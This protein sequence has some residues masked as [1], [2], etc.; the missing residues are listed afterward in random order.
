MQSV[1]ELRVVDLKTL[2]PADLEECWAC[3][4]RWWREQLSWDISDTVEA[5]RRVV[6][7]HGVPGQAV[8]IGARTVGYTYYGLVGRLGVISGVHVLP[9][10]SHAAVGAPLLQETV[11]A[12]RQQGATRIESP[13]LAM[14][15]PWLVPVL[16]QQGFQTHW[17]EFLRLD[18][19]RQEAPTPWRG[20][21]QLEPWQR[22]HRREAV[23]I[24]PQVYA[25]SSDADGN[26][27]YRTREGC[28]L[29]LE[30][31]L[32][33]GS[34]GRLI[35]TASACVRH[36]G[37]GIGCILVTEIAPAQ[38][39]L[40]QV[41]V[42]PDYQRQGVGRMLLRYSMSQLAARHYETLSLLVSRANARALHMYQTLGWHRV[43]AFPLAVWEQTHG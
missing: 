8:Q 9:A 31:L 41:M 6:A 11:A 12:M 17:R 24:M 10:W 33:Q 42:L 1:P 20:P 4:V 32:D 30:H 3:E 38:S 21:G 28:E 26:I 18:L 27:L 40:V 15:C 36:R 43:A 25:G 34:C 23:A 7:R 19:R 37:Q 39:H 35:D 5:L 13:C 14:D 29:V 2:G 22:L 16:A